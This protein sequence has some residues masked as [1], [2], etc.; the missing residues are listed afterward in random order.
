MPPSTMATTMDYPHGPT[1]DFRGKKLGRASP[2]YTE[3]TSGRFSWPSTKESFETNKIAYTDSGNSFCNENRFD[4][5]DFL[6]NNG[7]K[8]AELHSTADLATR[9][10]Q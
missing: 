5:N 2:I 4:T 10:C 1:S 3:Q 7:D 8:I 6:N 9:T